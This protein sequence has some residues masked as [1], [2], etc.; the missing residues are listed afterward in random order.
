MPDPT[1]GDH[2]FERPDWLT[3]ASAARTYHYLGIGINTYQHIPQLYN[4]VPDVQ[5]FAET[6]EAYGFLQDQTTLLLNEQA[7]RSQI[8]KT[9]RSFARKLTPQDNLVLYF[10][11]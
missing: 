2:L 8:L 1:R 11:G 5:T 6:L 7:S 9:L 3:E 10:A 4:P